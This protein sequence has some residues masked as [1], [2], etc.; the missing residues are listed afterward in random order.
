MRFDRLSIKLVVLV[1]LAV[2]VAGAHAAT[3]YDGFGYPPGLDLAGH[4]GGNGWTGAWFNQGGAP[5]LTTAAD[6]SFSDLAVT[7]GAATTPTGNGI[8]T[9]PRFFPNNLGADSS[10]L[11]LS[12][13]L[14]PEAGFGEYG[15]M[16]LGGFFVG[17]SGLP[18]TTYSLEGGSV[19]NVAASNVVAQAGTTVF[20]VMRGQ[21]Q[22]GN[23]IFDLFV[24]PEPGL[25]LPAAADATLT[26]VD[27]DLFANNFL[28]INNPGG[29]TIDEIRLGATFADV[30]PAAIPVP[31][32]VLLIA[33]GLMAAGLARG[34]VRRL[35]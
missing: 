3:V 17:K 11:F 33:G 26:N 10:T 21:F 6:L 15:G 9:Y 7:P 1:S 25:A 8:T 23:D 34:R 5:T 27:L 4:N 20:L 22:A 14:R 35:P 28:Y 18:V 19:G 32:S 16:N 12:F 2:S 30:S 31:S 29:W 13:L 24:N